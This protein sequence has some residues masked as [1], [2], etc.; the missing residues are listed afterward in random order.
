MEA[1]EL[2]LQSCLFENTNTRQYKHKLMFNLGGSCDRSTA[3]V[4]LL[5]GHD[6]RLP[7]H[8]HFQPT[9]AGGLLHLKCKHYYIG[10]YLIEVDHLM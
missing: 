10:F 1:G 8:S 6:D 2:A 9:L 5:P 3:L 7:C 4:D